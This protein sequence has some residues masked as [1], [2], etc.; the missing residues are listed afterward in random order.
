MA[1]SHYHGNV[2]V[3][4]THRNLDIT[5]LTLPYGWINAQRT[6]CEVVDLY[7]FLEVFFGHLAVIVWEGYNSDASSSR[8]A[9]LL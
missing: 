6:V 5:Y 3:Q 2:A 8:E 1:F 9:D 7:Q 4:V